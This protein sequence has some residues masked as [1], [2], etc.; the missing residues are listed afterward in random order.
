MDSPVYLAPSY[1]QLDSSHRF[2]SDD[3]M[4]STPLTPCFGSSINPSPLYLHNL[5]PSIIFARYIYSL[6]VHLFANYCGV[7]VVLFDLTTVLL[8]VQAGVDAK[9][10]FLVCLLFGP[11]DLMSRDQIKSIRADVE[12]YCSVFLFLYVLIYADIAS[13]SICQRSSYPNNNN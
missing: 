3:K 12:A 5:H 2:G 4:L 9:L 7:C 13:S 6:L 8:D 11:F 1:S 10:V